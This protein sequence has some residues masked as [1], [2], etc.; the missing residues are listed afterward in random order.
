MEYETMAA[1][2]VPAPPAPHG[3]RAVGRAALVCA[4]AMVAGLIILIIGF[5]VVTVGSPSATQDLSWYF[6]LY[7]IPTVVILTVLLLPAAATLGIVGIVRASGRDRRPGV[8]AIVVA[9]AVIM[10]YVAGAII[11]GAILSPSVTG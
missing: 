3:G 9:A 6:A 2:A 8:I 5:I 7:V 1:D 4:L 10:I 11:L